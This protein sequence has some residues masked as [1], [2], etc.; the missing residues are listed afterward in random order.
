ME[1]RSSY[2]LSIELSDI[3]R[4][5]NIGEKIVEF[6]TFDDLA[7][8]RRTSRKL[9]YSLP[10]PPPIHGVGFF[11]TLFSKPHAERALQLMNSSGIRSREEALRIIRSPVLM[12]ALE[13]SPSVTQK[14][15]DKLYYADLLFNQN[16]PSLAAPIRSRISHITHLHDRYTSSRQTID[17]L[18]LLDA[19]ILCAGMGYHYGNYI[20]H[21]KE[22]G[23]GL[24]LLLLAGLMFF[25]VMTYY[26]RENN[27]LLPELEKAG[28]NVR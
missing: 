21:G 14:V 27:Q 26:N 16:T 15:V 12:Q 5:G 23:I 6:L 18:T 13:Y 2:E 9:K 17:L 28:L 8:I 10:L 20:N 11:S 7:P 24:A 4:P 19:F 3:L 1:M 25:S 22:I